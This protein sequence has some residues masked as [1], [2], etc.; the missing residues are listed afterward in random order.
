MGEI[1]VTTEQLDQILQV[2]NTEITV[3]AGVPL[4]AIRKALDERGAFYPPVPTFEGALAGGVVATNA[5]GAGTFKYGSTRD[6]VS[7]LKV[8]LADGSVLE[9][10]RGQVCAHPDGYF[11]I[12]TG[13]NTRRV[14]VP[15]YQMPRVP[16]RSAGYYAAPEMDLIDLFVGS[17][18]TL[19]IVTEVTFAIVTRRPVICLAWVSLASEAEALELVTMLRR[20]AQ[21]TWNS[22]D[23]RGIDVAAIE[24][25]DRRS[26]DLVT[27]VGADRHNE[28]HIPDDSAVAILT[29]V[30]LPHDSVPTPEQA[31]A[32]IAGAL[33]SGSSDTPLVRL[34]RLFARAGLTGRTEFALPHDRRRQ[35]Q[36][37][38]LRESVPEAVNGAV[39]R[40]KREVDAAIEKTAADMIVP[41]NRFAES[42][43]SFRSA[44]DDRGLDYAIWG[45]ISDGNV[46]PN[47]IPQSYDNVRQG[48]AAILACG[49]EVI[50]MGG[51]PLAE[52]GVGRNPIKQKLLRQLYGESG[53]EE[54]R[55]VKAAVDPTGKLSP[56][57][58]FPN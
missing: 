42:L 27:A 10:A 18:G 36:L 51:C 41:F 54:M 34:C 3:Q 33:E 9:L 56:G 21:S 1:V 32:E 4:N 37:I 48:Q 43:E 7:R 35:Q 5:A 58:L 28:L 17:E 12:V 49:R 25:M 15:T 24:Y 47:V 11:E 55:W 38:A 2:G 57:V 53:I 45:H 52:H 22:G 20:E 8:V 19:G 39:G 44:F 40:A 26:L 31:Y 16:K 50:R 13:A 29:R 14:P 30:E 23:P 6:W 46:H